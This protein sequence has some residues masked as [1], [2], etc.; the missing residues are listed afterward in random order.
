M[1]LP[2]PSQAWTRSPEHTVGFATLAGQADPV[3]K[4]DLAM[5]AGPILSMLR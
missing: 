3:K 4:A 1:L 2:R 5:A